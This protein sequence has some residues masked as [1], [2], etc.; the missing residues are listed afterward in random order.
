[1]D[2]EQG[3]SI[4]SVKG[5]RATATW[6]LVCNNPRL[7]SRDHQKVCVACDEPKEPLAE[8]LAAR[9]FL[10]RIEPS[11]TAQPRDDDCLHQAIFPRHERLDEPKGCG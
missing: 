3:S 9:S 5:S 10:R 6:A 4:C 1:M 8:F 2:E 11:A 7:H